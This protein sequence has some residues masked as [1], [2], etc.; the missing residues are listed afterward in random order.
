MKS[1]SPFLLAAMLITAVALAAPAPSG[2]GAAPKK[3][4]I[5]TRRP[6]KPAGSGAKLVP[7]TSVEGITE[8]RLANGLQVLL[9]PD[10]TKPTATVNL[11]YRVGS[12]NEEYGETGMAH[13]LE[14]LMFKG[15]PEHKNIYAEMTAHGARN[16]ASTW[17]DRTNYFETFDASD[18]NLK[19]ALEL[20]ADRMVHSFIAKKD[21]AS[22]M[23]VVRNEFESGENDPARILEERV[24]STAYL[25]HNYGHSTIGARSDIEN[26][27]IAHL[28]AF[29]RLWYQPDNATLL[30]AGKFDP[31]K[32][33]AWI[34]EYFGKIPK[35]ARALPTF[36]TQEPT[37]DGER[38]VDLRRV[39]DVQELAVAYHVPAGSHPD[40]APID[41]LVQIL[42]DTPAG[43]LH[44]SL[45]ETHQA[46]SIGGYLQPLHDPG[47][48]LFYAEIP[49]DKP[50]DV[51]RKTMLATLDGF[52]SAPC[53][54]D[55]L[56]RARTQLLKDIDLT[57][58]NSAR[59]GIELSEW[60]GMGDW[61]LFFLHRDQ[62]R[63][64]TLEDVQRVAAEYL[65]PSNRT[66]G[67]FYPTPKPDRAEIPATPNVEAELAGYKGD[68][69][70]AAGEAF[71][72]S[73]ENIDKR[74]TRQKLGNGAEVALL[75]K[76]TRGETVY[77][78]GTLRFGTV[79]SLK[80]LDTAG[81]FAGDMLLRGSK[82]HTRQEIQDAFDKL[83]ARVSV[84]GGPTQA[85]IG[86]ETVRANL[87]DVL[88]L[89][90][91]VLREP[92]FPEKEFEL[93]REE[94][95]ADIEQQLSDPRA[96]AVNNFERHL[97]D[98]PKGDVRYV[99][100][101]QEE[102]ADVQ[103]VKLEDAKKFWERFYGASH[104][105]IAIV[106]D[107]DPAAVMP[108]LEEGLG[109]WTSAESFERVP[110]PFQDIA[111]ADR[112]FETPDKANAWF[113][114]G[115]NLHVRDTDPDFP[116]LLL[117]NY[118]FGGGFLN[119]RLATRI[120]QKEGL[121]YGVGSQFSASPF[122]ESGSF[123][124][125]AIYAP[126]NAAKLRTAVEEEMKRVMQD[127]FTED[128]VRQ[129]RSGLLQARQVSRAQDP[130]LARRLSGYL[131]IP[132]T[133]EYDAKV[134][135]KLAAMTPAEILAAWKRH[136]DPSKMTYVRAG[137]FA[138]ASKYEKKPGGGSPPPPSK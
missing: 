72:P 60:I 11:T 99:E 68:Q 33:L 48:V 14:H 91:E 7:V 41:L 117:G 138:N 3:P 123:L 101:P 110:H 51:A 64:A 13:L 83:K 119:S 88:K 121:S 59:V 65:K 116:A 84:G 97:N 103:A 94:S 106:G 24:L 38:D 69:A 78:S 114:A 56:D 42:A 75:P 109:S 90:V 19:W 129:A 1:K 133:M 93:L 87:P 137:D 17:F 132:R 43:R 8:Y 28:Q 63:K 37:Q 50:L 30:V 32:T 53:T 58:N 39:G 45:V 115:E 77:L 102:K 4:G 25:W 31:G 136:L 127:G 135:A 126:Q 130:E 44:K 6:A 107:F 62:I 2:Q 22:E 105:Q 71:D 100:T 20:E 74:T 16:N 57:L 98:F 128:E 108:V 66:V 18:A 5:A 46:S 96:I 76:K 27:P 35:P 95:L 104:A 26:V 70:I 15:T 73:P 12:R 111:P 92:A 79:E 125:Y 81:S 23:T 82:H 40:A 113:L 21:L 118:I 89:V 122:E 52:A 9:F 54:K 36:Y 67:A 120:R 112:S 47:F 34:R 49:P 29:Y 124:E 134:D 86:I 55:E 131:F 61:R 80:G 85:N 10:P